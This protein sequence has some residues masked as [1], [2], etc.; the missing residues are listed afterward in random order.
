MFGVTYPSPL[1]LGPVGVQ[2]TFTAE[3]EY[4]PAKAA[5][6]LGVPFV[7]S[8]A[9]TRSIE[10]VA[11]ASGNGPRW[12]QLYWY[13]ILDSIDALIDEFSFSQGRDTKK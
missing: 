2:G 12:Y 9:S 1:I 10:Q 6:K 8:S 13:V 11:Q 7:M 5:A 3:G 4:A